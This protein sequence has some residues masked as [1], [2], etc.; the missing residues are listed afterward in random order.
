MEKEKHVENGITSRA[1]LLR[2]NVSACSFRK[3][4]RKVSAKV[5]ADFKA[6]RDPG[7][8]NKI[9]IALDE[10]K[11]ITAWGDAARRYV[12]DHAAPWDE[13]GWW[14]ISVDEYFPAVKALGEI[15]EK[16]DEA[17]HKFVP[18]YPALVKDA[19]ESLKAMFNEADYPPPDDVARRFA[20]R[21]HFYPIPSGKHLMVKLGDEA[22][23]ELQ[24]AQ[25]ARTKEAV[26]GAM[27]SVWERLHGVV[28][29][30]ADRLDDGGKFHDTL[31]ENI[32]ELVNI[33][34]HLN[35]V[36]DEELEAMRREVE[37]KLTRFDPEVLRKS[38]KARKDTLKEAETIL[39]KMKGFVA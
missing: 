15:V 34:P 16:H 11:K 31:V 33:L 37:A 25:E 17:V 30:M 28:K 39:D 35:V 24:A 10:I 38:R 21:V 9:L 6:N 32:T 4:D 12:E 23:A 5:A 18:L 3:Y 29:H 19:R 2:L 20:I 1:M 22:L 26:Q 27:R 36:G 13:P 8:Y 14:I 7:R